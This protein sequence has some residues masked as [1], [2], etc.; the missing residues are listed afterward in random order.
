MCD[1]YSKTINYIY[2]PNL[3]I[4]PHQS[5]YNGEVA[6][7]V[8]IKSINPY[9]KLRYCS[10]VMLLVSNFIRRS[11]LQKPSLVSDSAPLYFVPRLCAYIEIQFPSGCCLIVCECCQSIYKNIALC[12][13]IMCLYRTVQEY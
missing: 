3:N 4:K 7:E 2:N 13:S 11:T 8:E 9:Y 10:I 6:Y 5:R 1:F 12:S